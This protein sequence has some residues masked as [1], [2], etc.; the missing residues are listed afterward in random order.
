MGLVIAVVD[1]G[2][3]YTKFCKG[4][5][6]GIVECGSMPSIVHALRA[7][8]PPD[9]KPTLPGNVTVALGRTRIEACPSLVHPGDREMFR[10]LGPGRV[11]TDDY[12]ALATAALHMMQVRFVDLLLL[13]TPVDEAKAAREALGHGF[14]AGICGGR[15]RIH[16][17]RVQLIAQPAAIGYDFIADDRSN[18]DR[19]VLAIVAGYETVDWGGWRGGRPVP[20]M[21]GTV[22][23]G[24]RSMLDA[25]APAVA[26][27]IRV[28]GLHQD[29]L[30]EALRS[31]T[32]LTIGFEQFD[33]EPYRPMLD[34][35]ALAIIR[36]IAARLKGAPPIQ[37][38]VVAGGG[39]T[40]FIDAIRAVFR[41]SA[42]QCL[43]EPHFAVARGMLHI[44]K[45]MMLE[46]A[47][48]AAAPTQ[49]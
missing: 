41:R 38:V 26:R 5:S 13:S 30:D 19:T 12:R 32:A 8:D 47:Q 44:G 17:S 46:L 33:L 22:R 49:A 21:A 48:S 14:S 25:V 28:E 31:R 10:H 45:K 40:Y 9:G 1:V 4:G 16:V 6:P 27:S 34:A 23:T 39:A 29:R 3:G 42:L 20:E 2:A 35:L 11:A 37:E 7:G 15:R 24:V 18:P 43:T 36:Q